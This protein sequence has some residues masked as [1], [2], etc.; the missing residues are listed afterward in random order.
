MALTPLTHAPPLL[1]T[2]VKYRSLPPKANTSVVLSSLEGVLTM[3]VTP[4]PRACSMVTM[5]GGN[6]CTKG[7]YCSSPC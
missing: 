5:K 6:S 2:R 4:P 3:R 1:W 7:L